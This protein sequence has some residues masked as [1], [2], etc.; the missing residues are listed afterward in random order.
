LWEWCLP[1]D[2]ALAA[3]DL[4]AWPRFAC[5]ASA[6]IIRLDPSDLPFAIWQVAPPWGAP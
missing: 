1:D 3:T 6:R 5:P 2:A 4:M